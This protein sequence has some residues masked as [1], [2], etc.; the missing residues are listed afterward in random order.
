[1]I[2]LI[3]FSLVHIGN[4]DLCLSAAY[5][6]PEKNLMGRSAHVTG[7]ESVEEFGTTGYGRLF[8][9]LFQELEIVLCFLQVRVVFKGLLP[10]FK[11]KTG[12]AFHVIAQT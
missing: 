7:K 12:E 3:H 11:S 9:L 8:S 1:M 4:D 5:N 2:L 6:K 10:F